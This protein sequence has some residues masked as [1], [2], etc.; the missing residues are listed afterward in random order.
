MSLFP[1]K[2][3]SRRKTTLAPSKRLTSFISDIRRSALR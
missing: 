1:I 3:P 2:R